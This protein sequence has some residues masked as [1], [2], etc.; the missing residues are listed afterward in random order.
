MASRVL[1]LAGTALHQNTRLLCA[2]MS[3]LLGTLLLGALLV[4][5]IGASGM[6]CPGLLPELVRPGALGLPPGCVDSSIRGPRV[7]SCNA[8]C[9]SS[10]YNSKPEAACGVCCACSA[11]NT[12]EPYM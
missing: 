10:L 4:I 2:L 12:G 1:Q 8:I 3:L 9:S 7:R 5:F 11:G 6:N